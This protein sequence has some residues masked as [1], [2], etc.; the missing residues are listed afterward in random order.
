MSV[1]ATGQLP[2]IGFIGTGTIATALVTA[3]CRENLPAYP[4]VVSPQYEKNA[5]YLQATYPQR[6]TVAENLQQVADSAD[7]LFLAVLPSAGEEVCRAINFRPEHK[8][9]NLISDKTLPQLREWIGPTEI[10]VH[11]IPLSFVANTR[12]PIVLCPYQAEVEALIAPIGQV[13][14]VD[15]RRQ[16]AVFAAVTALAASFFS[17]ENQVMDWAIGEGVPEDKAKLYTTE[18]FRAL[19]GQGC[20]CELPRLRELAEEMTPGGVNFIAKQY[21]QQHDGFE[22]WTESL[23]PCMEMLTKNFPD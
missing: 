7:W 20:A 21:L 11:M 1:P 5:A 14:A 15:D 22:L 4:I 9:I 16:A 23:A 3:L 19:A 18:F 10:L 13:V 17:L 8:I 2:T 6:V 12:G